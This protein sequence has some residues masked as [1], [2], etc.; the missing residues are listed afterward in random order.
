MKVLVGFSDTGTFKM[1]HFHMSDLNN[2]K[3]KEM[4]TQNI[5]FPSFSSAQSLSRV[6]PFA[7]PWTAASQA[8]LSITNSLGLLKLMFIELVMPS[9]LLIL[10]RPL[11]LLLSTFPSI[12]VFSNESVLLLAG[13]SIG[14]SASLLPMNIQD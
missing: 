7:T 9:T 2:H 4:Q 3:V 6:R 5:L 11:L 1:V 10:C 13:Q 12:R 14:A 8:F